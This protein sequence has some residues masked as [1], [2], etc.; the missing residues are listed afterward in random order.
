TYRYQVRARDAAGNVSP[1]SETVEITTLEGEPS[2][3]TCSAVP[4]VQSE[5]GDGYVIQPLTITNTGDA[6][7]TG[8]T[9]T[10]T[11]PAGHTLTGSWNADVTTSGQTVTVKN[12]GHNG[13]LAPGAATTSVGFQ[14][15]RPDGD[16]ALPSGYTCA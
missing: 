6:T 11:L 12:V 4:T 9:V 5:W 10:F 15:S 14:V 2:D 1:V 3:G 8:W 16:T 7:I 13:T